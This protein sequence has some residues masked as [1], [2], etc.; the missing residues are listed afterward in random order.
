M[1]L[2]QKDNKMHNHAVTGHSGSGRKFVLGRLCALVIVYVVVVCAAS[3]SN[4]YWLGGLGPKDAVMMPVLGSKD[5]GV[6][7]FGVEDH[8]V[9]SVSQALVFG[10]GEDFGLPIWKR[11]VGQSNW[12]GERIVWKQHR[13]D[14]F[15]NRDFAVGE[16][17]LSPIS[18]AHNCNINNG[19]L[20]GRLSCVDDR[21]WHGHSDTVSGVLRYL[22][23]SGDGQSDPSALIG[24]HRAKLFPENSARQD[25]Y[26]D[27]GQGEYGHD[28]F[29]DIHA[30]K[31]LFAW[32][33]FFAGLVVCG[34][35]LLAFFVGQGWKGWVGLV[36]VVAGASMMAHGAYLLM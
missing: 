26:H 31:P 13:S 4:R 7:V 10:W 15:L 36:C 34:A 33:G 5:V 1:H 28:S 24:F 6:G 30:P 20:G 23:N 14:S 3:G 17:R 2:T 32:F 35:G 19:V 9:C 18:N 11:W 12:Y 8:V 29:K 21:Y 16:S 25:S 27:T 22:G